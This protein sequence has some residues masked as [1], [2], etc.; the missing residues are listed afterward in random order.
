MINHRALR[1]G[2]LVIFVAILCIGFGSIVN[3][4]PTLG[5]S[6]VRKDVIVAMTT[7]IEDSGLLDDLV[8]AIEKK[9][10]YKLKKVAVGTGQALA[11]AEKGEV[12][13]LFVNS[14]K[15]ERNPESIVQELKRLLIL[16]YLLKYR[17]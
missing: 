16:S 9:T 4:E 1:H 15:A 6:P 11:L 13:A 12:D 3:Q 8:P 17:Q 2:C 5:Q 10:G 14:P 7:S